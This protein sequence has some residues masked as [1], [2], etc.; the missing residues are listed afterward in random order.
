MNDGGGGG[1][2][3]RSPETQHVWHKGTEKKCRDERFSLGSAVFFMILSI[4]NDINALKRLGCQP[5]EAQWDVQPSDAFKAT[6]PE[7]G[8]AAIHLEQCDI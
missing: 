3:A 5:P 2:A 4:F 1:V 8:E 6:E 7:H